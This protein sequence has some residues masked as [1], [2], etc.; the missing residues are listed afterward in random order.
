MANTGM[1][2]AKKVKNDEYYT[3]YSTI[4][5]ELIYYK[6]YL[7][8]KIVY[9]NCDTPDSNFVKF[10]NDVKQSWDIAEVWHLH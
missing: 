10:L 9:C 3:Q 7:R 6:D 4:E 5:R 8:G 2:N 1:V